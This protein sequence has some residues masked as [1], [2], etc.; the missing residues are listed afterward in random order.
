[1][2]F[3]ER[4]GLVSPRS[5]L[6]IEG[7]D[8]GLRNGLWDTIHVSVFDQEP[9]SWRSVPDSKYQ[10]LIM[11]LWHLLFKKP[12]DLIPHSLRSA[13]R[14][15]RD[16]F[17]NCEWYEAYDLVEFIHAE[18]QR[19]DVEGG[20]SFAKFVNSVLERELSAYRII[21]GQLT[22][23]SSSEEISSIE[24][25][26][27]NTSRLSGPHAH[28]KTALSLMS[29]RTSPDFRNSVKESISAVES[30][31][32]L[33]T[34]QPKATLGEALQRL[35]QGGLIHPALK[36]SLSALYGYTS[37]AEGIRHAMLDEPTLSLVDAKFMLVSC[38]G[39]TNYLVAKA[40]EGG[41]S[42]E[43]KR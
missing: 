36:K 18:L 1:M 34:G 39:F 42:I 22:P 30:I 24:E 4:Q 19:S 29:S 6:Q 11:R 28:L 25:A 13:V 12:V 16:F 8:D 37:D 31:A 32:K 2:K 7:M 20:K 26:L 35:E 10:M 15:V 3:S 40:A 27:K 38:T 41:I 9:E 17:F 43:E 33:L 5:I 14:E 21:G 23:I